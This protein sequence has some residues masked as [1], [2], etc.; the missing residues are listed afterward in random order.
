MEYKE[1]TALVTGVTGFLGSYVADR[2]VR[3]GVK[4]RG[5]VRQKVYLP[6][7]A[8]FDGD[9]ADP[10]TLAAA[11]KDVDYIVHCAVGSIRL[12]QDFES[13]IKLNVEGTRSL[14]ESAIRYGV[15]RFV[16]ISHPAALMTW[17]AYP[18]SPKRRHYGGW[19]TIE[20]QRMAGSRLKWIGSTWRF[21]KRGFQA[22]S[23]V[24]ATSWELISVRGG[25]IASPNGSRAEKAQSTAMGGTPGRW[26]AFTTCWI[27][28][29]APHPS[30][31]RLG[32]N[33]PS[34]TT[35]QPGRNMPGGLLAGWVS[36]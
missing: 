30:L 21:A 33:I 9:L 26:S 34:S 6:N 2:L 20:F 27:P 24:P 7:V 1:K 13:A 14:I 12:E 28:L 36:S 4:V 35:T 29:K 17:T 22:S 23:C 11:A 32:E 18:W 15:D 16:Q 3:K 31:L 25:V 19:M 8:P 10:A 5:L